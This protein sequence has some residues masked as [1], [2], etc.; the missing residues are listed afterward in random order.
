MNRTII[1]LLCALSPMQSSNAFDINDLVSA[2]Y[3]CAALH[4]LKRLSEDEADIC[5]DLYEQMK[6]EFVDGVDWDA[7]KELADEDRSSIS[8]QGYLRFKAW[9]RANAQLVRQLEDDA[10][11]AV[12]MN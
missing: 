1:A 10:L 5:A 4:D 8:Q 12:E 2:H 6:L 7:F 9:E 3:R 11:H